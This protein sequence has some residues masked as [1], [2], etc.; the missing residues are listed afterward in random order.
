MIGKAMSDAIVEPARAFMIPGFSK[1]KERTLKA[2]A[3]GVAISGAGPAI[4]AIVDTKKSETT[5]IAQA[6]KTGFKSVGVE[7]STFVTKPG[8]GV[9]LIEV[10]K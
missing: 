4:I 7:A 8:K 3:C 9:S 6:M 2:G 10:K 1:I 5:K